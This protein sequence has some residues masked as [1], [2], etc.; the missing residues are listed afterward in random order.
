M[1]CLV[2]MKSI[3]VFVLLINHFSHLV[4]IERLSKDLIK[5]LNAV[6]CHTTVFFDV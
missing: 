5:Y 6:V 4:K 2:Q 3:H 1:Q